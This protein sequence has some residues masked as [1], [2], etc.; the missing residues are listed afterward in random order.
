MTSS[1]LAA[2]LVAAAVIGA[3]I[4][5]NRSARKEYI[6]LRTLSLV[7]L[8]SA[9][10][11]A[12]TEDGLDAGA[13]SRIIQG[14]LTGIGFIGAGAI[15]RDEANKNVEGLTTATTVWVAAITGALCGQGDWYLTGGTI[16]LVAIILLLG[17]RF[18]NWI[19]KKLD[20]DHK[21]TRDT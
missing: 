11:V 15:L 13:A 2:R 17:N 10:I 8:G 5:L 4:G 21:K 18:E 19:M 3:M 7:S 1:D 14:L 20:A 16:I 9:A 6:G 12:G